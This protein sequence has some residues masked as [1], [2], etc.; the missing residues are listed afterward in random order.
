[1]S[2]IFASINRLQC[3]PSFWLA[4]LHGAVYTPGTK[5]LSPAIS[6]AQV[7]DSN[8]NKTYA[9]LYTAYKAPILSLRP[10]F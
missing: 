1:M 7:F 8:H 2:A 3:M 4:V 6:A 10:I 9:G 5:L